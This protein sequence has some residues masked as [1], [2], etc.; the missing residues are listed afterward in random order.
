MYNIGTVSKVSLKV[1]NK[2]ALKKKWWP[3]IFIGFFF[4]KQC[5]VENFQG[6]F[7]KNSSANLISEESP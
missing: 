6:K 1:V 5:L 2:I 3:I 4:S 7:Q